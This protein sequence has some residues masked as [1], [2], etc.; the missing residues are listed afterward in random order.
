MLPSYKKMRKNIPSSIKIGRRTKFK[1]E[2]HDSV[3]TTP[4]GKPLYGITEFKPN[5]I[6]I[7][8]GLDDEDAV[9]TFFHEFIHTTDCYKKGQNLHEKQVMKLEQRF[10][11]FN[12]FFLTLNKEDE[13]V[14]SI[15]EKDEDETT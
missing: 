6:K 11:Y 5:V 9:K 8:K 4:E 7:R 13:T 10:E 1:V 15:E 3:G 12:D 14:E 2:W